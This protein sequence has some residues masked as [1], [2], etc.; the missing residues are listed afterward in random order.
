MTAAATSG[1]RNFRG[2]SPEDRQAERRKRLLEA[3]LEAFGG[4]G[5]YAVGVRDVCALAKLTE[6][7]FYESFENREA[8][9]VAVYEEAAQRV[10]EAI[11]DAHTRAPLGV[12]AYARAGLEATLRMFRDD[13]RVARILLLEVLSVGANRGEASLMV[14]QGFADEITATAK[15]FFPDIEERTLNAEIVGNGLYGSTVYIAMR[16]TLGGF[17]EPLEVVLE[18]CLLFYEAL[19]ARMSAP[20]TDIATR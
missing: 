12:T 7:Y 4:R 17:R 2:V 20:H 5:F 11:A 3:G 14:S 15:A 10:R 16:W 1:R 18:H 19:E 9:F 13:P 6:R 8:L